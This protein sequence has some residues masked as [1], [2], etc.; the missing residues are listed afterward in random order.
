[1][2]MRLDNNLLIT[3]TLLTSQLTYS[4]IDTVSYLLSYY[5]I[6]EL[7]FAVKV[8]CETGAVSSC[9]VA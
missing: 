6:A 2:L 3:G 9:P 8:N 1:M 7:S 4:A 5:C